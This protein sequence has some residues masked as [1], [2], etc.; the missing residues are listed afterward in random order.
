MMQ[1]EDL[2][3]EALKLSDEEKSN[4]VSSILDS[5]DSPDP[6]DSDQD[7]LTEAVRRG[8]EIRA[9][10]VEAIPEKEFMDEIRSLRR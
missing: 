5:L 9:G 1:V 2:E 3:I 7:S 6:H 8:D 4:L 10:E